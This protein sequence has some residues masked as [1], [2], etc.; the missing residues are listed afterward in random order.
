MATPKKQ[1]PVTKAPTKKPAT[2]KEEP[3]K[4]HGGAQL[5]ANVKKRKA[6]LD[7]I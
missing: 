6:L 5:L 4:F 1:K 7:S 3:R 2:K